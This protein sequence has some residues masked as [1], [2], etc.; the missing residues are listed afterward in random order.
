M[1]IRTVYFKVSDIDKARLYWQA[2]LKLDPVKS[3]AKYCEFRVENINL[4]LVLNDFGDKF[5]G[6]NCVPVFEFSDAE[7][8]GYTE[9]AKSLGS[10]V[11]LDGLDDP[12]LLSVIFADPW[13]NEFELSKFHD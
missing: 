11:I 6:A 3:T 10:T 13:G 7:L 9:R 4:G 8:S 1:K 12:H 2:L 5:E